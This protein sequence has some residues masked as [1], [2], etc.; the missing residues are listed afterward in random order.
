ME[1][2]R[3]PA[4]CGLIL[5]AAVGGCSGPSDQPE[6]GEVTGNVTL[7][8]KPLTGAIIMFKPDVG[9]A[10]TDEIDENG[11]Y[12][13]V[14]RYG[15]NGAKVGP[16]TISFAWPTGKP[17]VAIPP[18]YAGESTLKKDVEAGGNTFDFALTTRQ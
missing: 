17:G 7:D 1:F 12:E 8:G 4:S 9:R 5:M 3:T 10:A 13:L 6:L 2:I 11:D 18:R 15:V 16:N 14:Y